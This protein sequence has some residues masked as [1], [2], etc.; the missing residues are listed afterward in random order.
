MNIPFW[1]LGEKSTVVCRSRSW[2]SLRWSGSNS[3]FHRWPRTFLAGLLAWEVNVWLSP[4]RPVQVRNP[5]QSQRQKKQAVTK[6]SLLNNQDFM[7]SRRVFYVAQLISNQKPLVGRVFPIKNGWVKKKNKRSHVLSEFP[8]NIDFFPVPKKCVPFLFHVFFLPGG[9]QLM[10]FR[11]T[12]LIKS[13]I[14]LVKDP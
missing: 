2:S 12:A 4:R 13:K 3:T 10:T 9:S 14:W 7:E 11:V 8:L 5:T 6:D 1:P